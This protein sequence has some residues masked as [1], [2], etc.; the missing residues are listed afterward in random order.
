MYANRPTAS[1]GVTAN[2]TTVHMMP[3]DDA[4]AARAAMPPI[5][6]RASAAAVVS[7]WAVMGL[8]TPSA[9]AIHLPTHPINPG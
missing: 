1:S 9:S 6:G 3:R 8:G 5:Q 2:A 4:P 7:L